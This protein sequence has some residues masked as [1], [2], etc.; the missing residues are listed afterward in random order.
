M[1]A[2]MGMTTRKFLLSACGFTC[3]AAGLRAQEPALAPQLSLRERFGFKSKLWP[4]LHHLLYVLARYR[5]QA[6][7]RLRVAVRDAPLD[8]EGFGALPAAMRADWEAAVAAYLTD[9][10]PLEID[11]GKLVDVN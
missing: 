11:R 2:A 5:T 3:F 1:A 8:T 9:A 10:A 4:N 6:P 7:D